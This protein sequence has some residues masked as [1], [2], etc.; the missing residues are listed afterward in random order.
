MGGDCER[1]NMG[2]AI[3]NHIH[4]NGKQIVK[5]N[6][7][8]NNTCSS[9]N[10]F[11]DLILDD[12]NLIDFVNHRQSQSVFNNCTLSNVTINTHYKSL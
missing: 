9:G 6:T 12:M 1:I 3:D 5:R 10:E 11:N 7:N 4:K 8:M 2:Q